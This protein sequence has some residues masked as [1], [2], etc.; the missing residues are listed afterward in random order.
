[1][2]FLTHFGCKGN[3]NVIHC[4]MCVDNFLCVFYLVMAHVSS[5]KRW[6]SSDTFLL[7]G[8]PSLGWCGCLG[9]LVGVGLHSMSVLIGVSTRN[10]LVSKFLLSGFVCVWKFSLADF[11]LFVENPLLFSFVKVGIGVSP[12]SSMWLG[13]SCCCL[14]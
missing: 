8:F 11:L 2:V 3:M 12:H 13:F 5:L 7:F 10:P 14:P 1:M 4:T 6:G 9:V